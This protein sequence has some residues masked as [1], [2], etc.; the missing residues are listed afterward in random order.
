MRRSLFSMM[1]LA[2]G[3]VSAFAFAPPKPLEG[4]FEALQRAKSLNVE[5]TVT[6]VGGAPRTVS[7]SLQ[8]PNLLR[9]ESGDQVVFADGT[10][11]VTYDKAANQFSKMEQTTESLLGLFEDTDMRFWRPFFDAKA[12]DGMTDVAKGSNVE[13]AGRRLTTVTGKMGITSSTMYLDSRDALLRQAEISQQMGGTTA[14]T[15]VNATKV[16]LNGEVASD[17]F[18][19][20]APSGATEVTFTAK[21]LYDFEAAKKL[22]KQTGRLLMVDFMADWCGPC[23]MLDAQVF[24]TPEFKKAAGEMV[25]VKVNIDNFPALASQYKATSIPLVVFMDGDGQVLHQSLG[26][27][28]VGEF[29]KEIAAAKSKG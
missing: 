3:M 26:F 17:L 19:F 2:G 1:A 14:R 18:A 22:A 25:W 27:K 7:L 6:M 15:V 23:K 20:K 9:M 10:T 16:E 28:P 12:F 21:W 13:R 5:Y 24:S 29:L 11:I 8:K 4:H